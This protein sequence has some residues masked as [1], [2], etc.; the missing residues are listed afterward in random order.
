MT[1]EVFSRQETCPPIWKDLPALLKLA[2]FLS[3]LCFVFLLISL[4]RSGLGNRDQPFFLIPLDENPNA[5]SVRNKTFLPIELVESKDGTNRHIW[6][7]R[8]N[9]GDWLLASPTISILLSSNW[10]VGE[11]LSGKMVF[12]DRI[13][14]KETARYMVKKGTLI[15]ENRKLLFTRKKF[16]DIDLPAKEQ[17]VRLEIVSRGTPD[18]GIA[19]QFS[20][21]KPLSDALWSPMTWQGEAGVA[22]GFGWFGSREV[23]HAISKARLLSYTWGFDADSGGI[24]YFVVVSAAFFW[25][26]GLLAL[27]S[28]VPFRKPFS[29]NLSVAL[30]AGLLFL[31]VGLV[32]GLLFPPFQCGDE[33]DHFLNYAGLNSRTDLAYD[34]LNLANKGH[35][36]RI[37][38]RPDEHFATE[39]IGFPMNG[40]WAP[41]IEQGGL[42]RS[43]VAKTIWSFADSLLRTQNSGPVLLFLRFI[44]VFFVSSCLTL[45]LV[46]L[47]WGIENENI[48]ALLAA[49]VLLT[50]S[51][52]FFSMGVSNYPF[53]VGGYVIQAIALGSIWT[54][55]SDKQNNH[56]RA[57][58]TGILIGFGL[59]LAI[60][61]ADNGIFS[62]GFWAV[63]IP[64]YWFL[65]G[66][67]TEDLPNEIR[68]GLVFFS[69]LV[70]SLLITWLVVG[71]SAGDFHILPPAMTAFIE[72]AVSGN[73]LKELGAQ[74]LVFSGFSG[75][76]IL[77]SFVALAIGSRLH[78][79]PWLHLGRKAIILILFLAALFVL[80]A[81]SSRIPDFNTT[82]ILE[83][84]LKVEY[85]FFEGFGPGKSDWL[86][87]QS[88]WGEFGW[89][90]TSMPEILN[91]TAR[92][93]ATFGLLILFI[94]TLRRNQYFHGAG[95]FLA[96]LLSLII[97]IA[98][99]ASGYASVHYGVNGRYLIGPYL[100]I[101]AMAYAGYRRIA[102]LNSNFLNSALA[103]S[104]ICLLAATFHLT[105]WMSILDRYF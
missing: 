85:S 81:K 46:L 13:S 54:E 49:P 58:A 92:Y 35:F 60:G 65:R 91:N 59:V 5:A 2:A 27:T 47:A 26:L 86:V 76:V 3:L 36:E 105:A 68:K 104:G 14:G 34:A 55:S 24:V 21:D 33:A 93:A 94:S 20:E 53:L 67:H 72:R 1:S 19:A 39:D 101:L 52:A 79:A 17:N 9:A 64:L 70:S 80:F 45:S 23:F 90:D 87:A 48:S 8:S 71:F 95:F 15:H 32:Y 4:S 38:L 82:P 66:L 56:R 12:T 22:S 43:V 78:H 28:I 102:C 25:L 75:P 89:L 10:K 84:I 99:V 100:L 29:E 62:I 88:F 63:L 18:L 50:P 40:N 31:S 7:L 69:A 73:L 37:K 57:L 11:V 51:V 103:S 98:F 42:N 6:Q 96:N 41:H 16:S 83:Y 44:N 30:G 61:S 74:T 77:L 97:F